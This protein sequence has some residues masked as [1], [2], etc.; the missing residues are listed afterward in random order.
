[1]K[2]QRISIRVNEEEKKKF[3]DYAN[4]KKMTISDYIRYACLID[5]KFDTIDRTDNNTVE[6]TPTVN[7]LDLIDDEDED[8]LILEDEPIINDELILDDELI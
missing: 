5:L 2:K 6:E 8:E 1:M 3:A 4:Q 7:E